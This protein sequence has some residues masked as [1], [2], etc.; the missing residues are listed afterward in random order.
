[1]KQSWPKYA[2]KRYMGV[3]RGLRLRLVQSR[4][5][6]WAEVLARQF[7]PVWT[8]GLFTYT[9]VSFG[10]LGLITPSHA[11]WLMA[12]VAVI[13]LGLLAT[14]MRGMRMP[15]K[16]SAIDR[17]DAGLK[18]SPLASLR[19]N[20][21]TGKGD[22][23]TNALWEMHQESMATRAL[24]AQVA[25]ADLRL[26]TR[27]RF[28][29]RLMALVGAMA[30]VIFTSGI[31]GAVENIL[32]PSGQT[33]AVGPSVEAWAN[34]PVYTG[35]PSIYLA[36]VAQ[37]QSLNLPLGTEIV[38]RVYGIK[39]EAAL[40]ETVSGAVFALSGDLATIRSASFTVTKSGQVE[41]LDG[42]DVLAS[43]QVVA[44]EDAP[45]EVLILTEPTQGA[46]GAMELRFETSD[47]FG[48]VAGAAIITLDLAAVD[49]RYGLAADP[50]PRAPLVTD[51][52][53]P[54][55]GSADTVVDTLIEDFSES[56]WVGLP[57]VFTLTVHDAIEQTGTTEI[58]AVLPGKRFF[59]PLA[60]AFAEQRRDLL[61]SKE[62]DR[63]ALQVLKAATHLPTDLNLS[64]GTY[65]MVRSAI[66]RFE[67]A[68]QGGLSDSARDEVAEAFWQIANLLEDGDLADARERLRRAQEKLLQAI[69]DDASEEEIAELMDDLRDATEEYMEMLAQEA[70]ENDTVEQAENQQMDGAEQLQKLL[71]E[72]QELAES[73][74]ADAAERLMELMREMLDN[75]QM[76]EQSGE[77]QSEQMQ[78]MLDALEQQ[79]GLSDE[80][81]QQLQELLDQGLQSSP[82]SVQ[83]LAD[84]QEEL[85]ELLDGLGQDPGAAQAQS[86]QAEENMGDARDSLQEGDLGN[87][88]NDQAKAIENLREGLRE[89]GEEMQQ[90]GQGRDG[91]QQG[92]TQNAGEDPLGRPL[93]RTGRSQT[94]ESLLSDQSTIDRARELLDEIRRRS[95]DA[96]RPDKE[97]DYLERLL[98]RF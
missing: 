80:T 46:M 44:V 39:G 86:E 23:L 92:D 50:V 15:N 89:L 88:L 41:V 30:A 40:R 6:L 20:P 96:D 13:A 43:W 79:Q 57:V 10:G 61:W 81:F 3:L 22:A 90:A 35:Q 69:E 94:T 17:I 49:R 76:A 85:R 26:A 31:N 36:E 58:H 21:A 38:M 52:P 55:R 78:Q 82:E 16:A 73:G 33:L 93:G 98:D 84:R 27:D 42:G 25:P 4:L 8:L 91:L 95:G 48:V 62:N 11:K 64:T 75:M 34:P 37:G 51:L 59:V 74:D 65:L 12:G 63:R 28:G 97:I 47:D 60:A 53:M 29:L 66:R 18:G 1:M 32:T 70:L 68:L 7:W 19:D 71:D 14:G 83:E 77:G 5:A 45:P 2:D 9:F 56:I 24:H 72:L 67:T 87:A 54:L